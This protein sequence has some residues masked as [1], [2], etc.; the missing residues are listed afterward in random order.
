M[1]S[2]QVL[3]DIIDRCTERLTDIKKNNLKDVPQTVNHSIPLIE[4][5][6]DLAIEI[7]DVRQT[8]TQGF[9]RIPNAQR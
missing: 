6:R 4:M 7:K 5:I 8:L 3:N 9:Q 2:E 1:R